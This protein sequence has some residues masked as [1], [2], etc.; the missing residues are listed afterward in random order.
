MAPLP[1]V[2]AGTW[3]GVMATPASKDLSGTVAPP[4]DGAASGAV[5]ARTGTAP[6]VRSPP[7]AWATA[8]TLTARVRSVAKSPVKASVRVA[9]EEPEVPPERLAMD[10]FGIAVTNS[11]PEAV[12]PLPKAVPD[13]FTVTV[14]LFRVPSVRAAGLVDAIDAPYTRTSK[15]REARSS[16]PRLESAFSA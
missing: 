11:K 7:R 4:N 14:A 3:N 5:P 13:R 15:R 9:V 16:S 8:F 10:T 1:P 2:A 6:V 12:T